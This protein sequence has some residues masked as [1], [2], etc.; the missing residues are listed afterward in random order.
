VS[1]DGQRFLFN[2]LADDNEN[3]E[4]TVMVNWLAQVQR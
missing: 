4:L 2:T 3:S 1:A